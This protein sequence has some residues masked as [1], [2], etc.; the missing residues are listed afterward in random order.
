[1]A[2]TDDE[3]ASG[4]ARTEAEMGSRIRGYRA[5]RKLSLRELASRAK[6]SAG[7]LS[8][9]ERGQVNASVGTLRRLAEE[10]G[11]TLPDL[12]GDH[13]V[14]GARILRRAD[15]P[16]IHVDDLSSKYLL[17][18]KP[19]MNLEVYSAEFAPGGSAGEAYVHGD[20]QEVLIVVTGSLV[21]E[22]NGK[23]HE[24]DAGDSAEYRTSI[25][26]TVYNLSDS[27]AELLWIVSPPTA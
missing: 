4:A 17:S 8:D 6:I 25:P 15:R 16:E 11:V 10:L 22:L 23:K 19:L 3:T 24:L 12:F 9:L 21:L 1:V 18:Q 26:H 5:T 13:H 27:P 20:A 2:L 14:D 7:F